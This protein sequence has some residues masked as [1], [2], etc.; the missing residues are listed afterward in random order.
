MEKKS[1]SI[2]NINC[3]HCIMAIKSELSDIQGVSRIEGDPDK[4]EITIV[5]ESPATLDLIKTA[6][7]DINYPAAE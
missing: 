1:F 6:L 3:G 5:W 7:K 2:P 4:K